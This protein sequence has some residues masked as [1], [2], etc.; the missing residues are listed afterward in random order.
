MKRK[1]LGA[2]AAACL[3]TAPSLAYSQAP[4]SGTFEA[5][6]TAWRANGTSD[7]VATITAG[8]TVDF[9]YPSGTSAHTLHWADE[10]ATCSGVPNAPRRFNDAKP[11]WH[12]TCR[13]AATGTYNFH[14]DFHPYMEG[15]VK[16]V[17]PEPTP[18][19]TATATPDASVTPGPT[20][21]PAPDPTPAVIPIAQTQNQ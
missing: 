12:G 14:C 16:V 8:G 3:V 9:S 15:T 10:G 19:A 18:T 20:A 1:L 7:T 11:G 4:A 5:V 2:A 6:D 21:T 13:F 17:A